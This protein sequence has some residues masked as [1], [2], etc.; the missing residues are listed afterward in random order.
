[1]AL[2]SVPL[3]YAKLTDYQEKSM[4]NLFVLYA[5]VLPELHGC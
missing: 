3:F 4:F 5:A 1:M 2:G